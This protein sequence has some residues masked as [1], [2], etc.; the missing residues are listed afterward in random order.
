[1]E[2]PAHGGLVG[3][4]GRS[5]GGGRKP[6]RG[7]SVKSRGAERRG[8]GAPVSAS[9]VGQEGERKRSTDDVSKTYGRPRS[10]TG[11]RRR[12]CACIWSRRGSL[13]SIRTR[14]GTGRDA[15][16][17]RRWGAAGSGVGDTTG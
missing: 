16:L 10:P 5:A 1:M 13:A 11:S 7:A 17:W 8:E 2:G 3:L 6:P 14:T 15:R 12:S 9:G 4:R